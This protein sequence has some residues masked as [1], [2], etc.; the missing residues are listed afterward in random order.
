MQAKRRRGSTANPS[1]HLQTMMTSMPFLLRLEKHLATKQHLLLIQVLRHSQV[2]RPVSSYEPDDGWLL[3]FL[4]VLCLKYVCK[5][6]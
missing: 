5:I 1:Q 6:F 3:D 2:S 4:V